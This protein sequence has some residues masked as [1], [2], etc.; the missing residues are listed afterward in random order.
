M[1][2]LLG[3]GHNKAGGW[4]QLSLFLSYG[5]KLEFCNRE[6][7]L[8][9]LLFAVSVV[10]LLAICLAPD[11]PQLAQ[12]ATVAEIFISLFLAVQIAGSRIFANEQDNGI[13]DLLCTYPLR[14]EIWY[15][16]KL[17]VFFI[18]STVFVIPTVVL[19]FVF[20]G[21]T[22]GLVFILTIVLVALF[23]L[24]TV[25]VLLAVIVRRASA[26]HVLYPIIFFPLTTPLLIASAELSLA[27]LQMDG[28]IQTNWLS[29]V[30]GFAIIYFT[31]GILLFGE[32]ID[33]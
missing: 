28:L 11:N 17:L 27:Y 20:N 18:S 26:R 2:E 30:V 31:L 16:G 10:V 32:L 9:P 14:R 15:L 29:I 3:D 25:A 8:S 24:A 19:A 22:D 1:V 21:Q 4:Q 13:L 7:L 5:L 23:A 6:R 33:G 12:R